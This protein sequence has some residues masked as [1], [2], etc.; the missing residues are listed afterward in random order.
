MKKYLFENFNFTFFPSNYDIQIDLIENKNVQSIEV[1]GTVDSK[2]V[3][4][5]NNN[6]V[7]LS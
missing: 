7:D 2:R 3:K 1:Y 4:E 5:Y 6:F